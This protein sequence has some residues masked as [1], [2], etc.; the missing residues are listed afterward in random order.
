ML[1]VE[2]ESCSFRFALGLLLQYIEL[3]LENRFYIF[4]VI[5]MGLFFSELG[6]KHFNGI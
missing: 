4:P 6:K 5:E 2:D 3:F 1:K